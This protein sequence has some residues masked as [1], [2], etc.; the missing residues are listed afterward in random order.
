MT[1]SRRSE[2]WLSAAILAA[3]LVV[4]LV[5]APGDSETPAVY[6]HRRQT[7]IGDAFLPM[8]AS[9]MIAISALCH[10]AVCLARPERKEGES[11]SPGGVLFQIKILGC[12]AAGF[13][14]MFWLGPALVAAFASDGLTYRELRASYPWKVTGFLAGGA[15][16]AGALISLVS[17][18]WSARNFL[19]GLLASAAL[20]ALFDLPFSNIMLPPNG[21][22]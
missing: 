2:I 19:L 5:W 12:V 10:I 8:L 6:S 1:L 22:W 21:D 7:F 9:A 4:L 14:I 17:K 20:V 18:N 16:M 13:L 11:R 15:F 3:S